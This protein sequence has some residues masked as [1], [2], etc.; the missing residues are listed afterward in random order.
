M[1]K[2][3]Y[4]LLTPGSENFIMHLLQPPS[5]EASLAQQLDDDSSGTDI[6]GL[7][8]FH[9]LDMSDESV[10]KAQVA[11]GT[12]TSGKAS[13]QVSFSPLDRL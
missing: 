6:L 8:N 10:A 7:V 5:H 13:F 2:G 11:P 3:K 1:S 4:I 9:D 12:H